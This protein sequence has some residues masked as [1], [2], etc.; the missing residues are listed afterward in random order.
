MEDIHATAAQ[1]VGSLVAFVE[2]CLL[3][4]IA[5]LHFGFELTLGNTTFAFPFLYPAAIVEAVLACALL[6]AVIL[7]GRGPV[8]AGRVLAAQILVVVGIFA[9]QVALMRG[10]SLVTTRNEFIYGV[11]LVLAL[12]SIALLASPSYR[13][14]PVTR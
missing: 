10:S 7:P 8:R 5:S 14:P 13:R 2:A 9:E 6:L 11:V 12:A 4:F 3:A 1:R